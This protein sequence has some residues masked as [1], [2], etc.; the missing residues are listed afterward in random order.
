MTTASDT[1][2]FGRLAS[3]AFSLAMLSA[4]LGMSMEKTVRATPL[5]TKVP[6]LSEVR[7]NFRLEQPAARQ[8]RTGKR[9]VVARRLSMLRR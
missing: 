4:L 8:R 2:M 9:A 3:E 7:S 5:E 6:E 1:S